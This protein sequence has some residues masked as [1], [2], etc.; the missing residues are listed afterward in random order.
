MSSATT[1]NTTPSPKVSAAPTLPPV[2]DAHSTDL[3]KEA[4]KNDIVGVAGGLP[5]YSAVCGDI[6][7]PSGQD[8]GG[9][10]LQQQLMLLQQ[11]QQL[12]QQHVLISLRQ[13]VCAAALSS[14]AA[15]ITPSGQLADALGTMMPLA[16]LTTT[17][18]ATLLS[19]SASECAVPSSILEVGG[20]P[21]ETSWKQTET[22]HEGDGTAP[23]QRS[24]GDAKSCDKNGNGKRKFHGKAQVACLQ[25]WLYANLKNPYPSLPLKRAL[26]RTSGLTEAQVDHWFNNARKRLLKKRAPKKENRVLCHSLNSPFAKWPGGGVL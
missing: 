10:T 23:S 8:Q 14:S 9:G 18:Q 5:D 24:T 11:L 12:Q 26:A 25:K 3:D 6:M 13:A 16:P 21:A 2:R 17:L 19:H 20:C 1:S 15:Q 4:D 7:P 22:G